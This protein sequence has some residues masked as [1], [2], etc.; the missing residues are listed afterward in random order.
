MPAP[1]TA[2]AK[3]TAWRGDFPVE[4]HVVNRQP[5]ADV[6]TVLH[7]LA[8][9]TG[10]VLLTDEIELS[11]APGSR[12]VMIAP[13]GYETVV[14]GDPEAFANDIDPA[15]LLEPASRAVYEAHRRTPVSV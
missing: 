5:I 8:A 14:H 4:V 3:I 1:A 12:W 6:R 13:D 2:G 10:T 11:P 7:S 9:G 15:I